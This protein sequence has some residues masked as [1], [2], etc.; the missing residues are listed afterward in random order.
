MMKDGVP[1]REAAK[2]FDGLLFLTLFRYV[3]KK[4]ENDDFFSDWLMTS[5]YYVKKFFSSDQE[6]EKATYM[7]KCS[8][9][10]YGKSDKDFHRLAFE[11]VRKKKSHLSSF[12]L[13]RK[14]RGRN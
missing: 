10:C 12:I 3:K 4:M 9:T 2:R 7:I 13:G 5:K 11:K 6:K 1:L 8:Q 14:T